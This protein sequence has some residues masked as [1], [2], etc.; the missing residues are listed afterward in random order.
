MSMLLTNAER[1]RFARWL[2]NEARTS[3]VLI[4]QMEK[5]SM[6]AVIV[7]HERQEMEAALIIARKI[8]QTEG[9]SV[10]GS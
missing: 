7:Q 8:R 5:L 2:E 6:G 4:E 1:E 10:G 3:K 9:F